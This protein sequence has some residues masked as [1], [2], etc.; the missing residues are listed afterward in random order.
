L[1]RRTGTGV[2]SPEVEIA[3]IPT[4]RDDSATAK[5]L[6]LGVTVIPEMS[7]GPAT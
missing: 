1:D 2:K 3:N 7:V 5:N 4:P 6:P